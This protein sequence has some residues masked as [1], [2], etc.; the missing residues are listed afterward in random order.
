MS[1]REPTKEGRKASKDRVELDF[2][3]RGGEMGARMRAYDWSS[4]PLGPPASW[5]LP[6]RTAIRLILNTGHPMYVWWGRDYFAS[7]TGG[8]AIDG[9]RASSRLPRAVRP[10]SVGRDLAHIIGPQIEQVMSAAAPPAGRTISFRSPA[11]A[12]SKTSNG[13]G[14]RPHRQLG[15]AKRGRRRAGGVRRDDRTGH[16]A[17]RANS[18]PSAERQHL[19]LQQ[20]PGFAALLTGPSIAMNTSATPTGRSP[21][22]AILSAGRCARCSGT[23]RPG[24][25]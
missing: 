1:K 6:L 16:G 7:T 22:I 14:V 25:L 12:S 4:H 13:R 10:R 21:A 2:M 5:P 9:P 18:P 11:T 15:C 23:C 8:P 19:M 24:L 3:A 17:P 20:M